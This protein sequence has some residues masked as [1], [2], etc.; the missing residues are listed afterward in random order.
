MNGAES[1]IRTMIDSDVRVCFGNPGTSEMHFVAALNR[2]SEMRGILCLFEGVA[3]GAADGYGRMTRRP[4]ATLLHLGPGL[5]NGLANLHNAR[6]AGTPVLN[7]VGEHSSDHKPLDSPLDSDI[8][9]VAGAVS[10]WLYRPADSADLGRQV[11]EA[12]AATRGF[13]D[14]YP[15]RTGTS[16]AIATVVVPAD[17]SWSA[18][19]V[20]ALPV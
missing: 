20:A 5:G 3:T 7:I 19:G 15:H 2:Y 6:R 10:A 4:A 12:I 9:A 14:S 1:I 17:L 13:T 11:A 16:G 8:D 18:G